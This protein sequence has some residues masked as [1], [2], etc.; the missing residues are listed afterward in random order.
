MAKEQLQPIGDSIEIGTARYNI[1]QEARQFFDGSHSSNYP[2]DTSVVI[3]GE[4]HESSEGQFNLF[5]G[6]ESFF[7]SN[8]KLV[9][10]TIFLSEGTAAGKPIS[11]QPLINEDPHPSDE[12]I[13]Q[14]LQSHLI[15]GYM[16]Y[17]WKYQ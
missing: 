16:A 9:E 8:P 14:V 10:Q 15:T 3:I 5:K 1:S 4:P 12:T 17:E 6:L 2:K 13:R 7:A 11:V